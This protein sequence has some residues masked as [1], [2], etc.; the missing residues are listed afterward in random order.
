MSILATVV[1]LVGVGLIVAGAA[2]IYLPAAAIL[3][4]VALTLVGLF[5]VDVD[6]SS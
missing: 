1:T 4:G 2:A 6:T 5:V 3:A